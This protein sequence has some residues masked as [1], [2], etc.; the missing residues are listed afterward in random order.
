MPFFD[1]YAPTSYVAVEYILLLTAAT[2]IFFKT[3]E[4]SLRFDWL[5]LVIL[6]VVNVLTY[7]A[8]EPTVVTRVWMLIIH[9]VSILFTFRYY[10]KITKQSAYSNWIKYAAIV[11][12]L[13]LIH[14]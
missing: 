2:I 5:A 4:H 11:G 9:A 14:I 1:A 6:F 13:S 12:M 10:K 3:G 7:L 8:T